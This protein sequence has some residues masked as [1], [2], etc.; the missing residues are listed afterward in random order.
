M[1]SKF[2]FSWSWK[3]ACGLSGAKGRLSRK[4]GI[5][6]TRSGRQRKIGRAAGCCVLC[7]AISGLLMGSF[8]VLLRAL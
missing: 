4:I 8:S 2:G 6:L 1:G 5:P 7:M 3:R